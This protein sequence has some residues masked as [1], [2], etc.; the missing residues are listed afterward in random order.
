M[1]ARA[2]TSLHP[3]PTYL[4]SAAKPLPPGGYTEVRIPIDPVVHAFQAGS[5]LRV[6]ISAPGGDRPVW[7]FNTYQSGGRVVD[8]AALGGAHPSKLVLPVVAGLQPPGGLPACPSLRGEPCRP[9]VAAGNGG[10]RHGA[11]RSRR[12][13]RP[14]SGWRSIQPSSTATALGSWRRR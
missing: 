12:R 13:R 6:T 3:V 4:A 9:Y 8:T 7:A 2:S 14:Q 11:E 5:R 1:N 10:E